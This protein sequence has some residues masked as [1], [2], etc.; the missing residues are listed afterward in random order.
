M[1]E[2]SKIE[3]TDHT[4]NPWMGCTK[5]SPACD[6]CYAEAMMDHR[7]G[8]VKWG[9]HGERV[10]T[11]PSNWK[12]PI[13]WNK[14]AGIA[15]TRPRV[16]CA[17][18]AD[19]FDNQVPPDWRF[20]LFALI[21]ATPNLIW[22][23][24]TKRPQNIV[25]LSA[26]AA[27]LPW[28]AAIGASVE[29]QVRFDLNVPAL[30]NAKKLVSPAFAFLSCEPL[31]GPLAGDLSDID[32]VI[33]GGETDQGQHKARPSH[34]DW[35]RGL[36]DQ[37]IAA[38]AAFHFKQWGEWAD[39]EDWPSEMQEHLEL[40]NKADGSSVRVGKKKAGRLLDGIEHN[41]FPQVSA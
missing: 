11:A 39:C 24:L 3:W 4:F 41:G 21:R 26:A 15:G 6:G 8:K 30:R 25:R 14:E 13:R 29:D 27:G 22:L 9:P 40:K 20:D 16:F 19:V 36:R 1:G 10:R 17:S 5:V 31:L 38:G 18:L 37:S 35:F 32:W 34:P 2:N 28:N 12:Q 33:A 7:Y 23:L